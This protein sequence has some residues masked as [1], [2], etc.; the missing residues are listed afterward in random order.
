M[1]EKSGEFTVPCHEAFETLD[2]LLKAVGQLPLNF[3]QDHPNLYQATM[4]GHKV[5]DRAVLE[6]RYVVPSEE[7][8][9]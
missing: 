4:Q 2:G 7:T 1:Q 9:K 5:I 8:P 3:L 6:G